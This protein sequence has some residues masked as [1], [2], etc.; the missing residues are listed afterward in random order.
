M[1]CSRVGGEIGDGAGGIAGGSGERDGR[2]ERGRAGWDA[3]LAAV[4]PSS[5]PTDESNSS[6][7][8][9]TSPT[10][11]RQPHPYN[12]DP[13]TA[14]LDAH[15]THGRIVAGTLEQHLE[16]L[17]CTWI[18]HHATGRSIA[19]VASTND[20][21]DTISQSINAPGSTPATATLRLQQR[22]ANGETVHVGDVIVTRRNDRQLVTSSGEPDRNRDTW[23]VTAINED[24]S[25]TATHQTGHGGVT[26]PADYVGVHVRLG[27]CGDRAR[28]AVRHTVDTAI[29]PR[30]PGHHAARPLRRRHPLERAQRDCV[31]TDSDDLAEA[32]DVLETILA[33]TASTSPPPPSGAPRPVD[34]TG[35]PG[36]TAADATLRTP[37]LVAH[38][39]RQR[40]TR[41]PRGA[42]P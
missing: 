2:G 38:R 17:A 37:L 10:P 23:S 33:A 31:I 20:H 24:E 41:P 18:D 26:I 42:D 25:I 1:C 5:A 12:F 28:L 9:T 34:A 27:L 13:V 16:R 8:S 19:V 36:G 21:V 6:N 11:G 14:V 29:A 7:A 3:L 35:D 39:P 15:E 22:V 40:P 4:R 32:R 30:L